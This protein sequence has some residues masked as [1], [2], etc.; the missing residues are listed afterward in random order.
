MQQKIRGITAEHRLGA[1][2]AYLQMRQIAERVQHRH[3]CHHRQQKGQ[4]IT[5]TQIVVDVAEQHQHQ[6]EGEHESLFGGNDKDAPLRERDRAGLDG[7]AVR[8]GTEL[9]L[10]CGE[11]REKGCD[12]LP[13]NLTSKVS[14]VMPWCSAASARIAASVPILN[15]SC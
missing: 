15:G 11:H 2:G 7:T 1:T 4:H 9:L 14:R 10:K 5:E 13:N 12:Y 6:H 3:P 8:P